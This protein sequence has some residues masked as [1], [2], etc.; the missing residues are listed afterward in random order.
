MSKGADVP[1][2]SDSAS[3]P[4][5]NGPESSCVVAA[6]DALLADDVVAAREALV[7]GAAR[8]GWAAI[9]HRLDVV[10]RALATDAGLSDEPGPGHDGS[11]VLLPGLDTSAW[12]RGNEDPAHVGR[13]AEVLARWTA[14]EALDRDVDM[15]RI[16][17]SLAV[18]TFL[19]DRAGYPAQVVV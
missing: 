2:M 8:F 15:E 16:W 7:A 14:D 9:A 11:I 3:R 4:L 17:S 5:V 19:V 10:G 13:A 1:E 18:V 12:V 6:V